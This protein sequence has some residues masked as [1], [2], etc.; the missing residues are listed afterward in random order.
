MDCSRAKTRDPDEWLENAPAVSRQM[1]V[2]LR[3]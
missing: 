1:A 3:E 2:Q